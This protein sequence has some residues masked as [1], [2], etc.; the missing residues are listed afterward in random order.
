MGGLRGIGHY[1]I[2][3][4]QITATGP[5]FDVG[6]LPVGGGT[7]NEAGRVVVQR[8]GRDGRT[9][10]V[11]AVINGPAVR[12]QVWSVT[13]RNPYNISIDLAD[14]S[15][16]QVVGQASQCLERILIVPVHLI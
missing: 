15:L 8:E 5:N 13:R 7:H 9:I 11:A 10:V 12:K 3:N 4:N 14:A 1:L 2:Q 16:E 6:K